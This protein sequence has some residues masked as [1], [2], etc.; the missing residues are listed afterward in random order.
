[1]NPLNKDIACK[2]VVLD[3]AKL[4]E[5]IRES[6]LVV[7]CEGGDGCVRHSAGSK[8]T[9]RA[10]ATGIKREFESGL[11]ERLATPEEITAA[12]LMAAEED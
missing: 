1:M 8:I 10:V 12:Q 2:H 3:R 7:Y 6:C 11:I 5:E 9:G 4:P